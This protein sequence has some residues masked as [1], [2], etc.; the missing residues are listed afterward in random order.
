ML[1][2]HS[3][4]KVA[5]LSVRVAS[6][7]GGYRKFGGGGGARNMIYKL[8][9]LSAIFLMTTVYKPGVGCKVRYCHMNKVSAHFDCFD[10]LLIGD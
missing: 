4:F 5:S 7:S 1:L 2:A 10:V 6:H 8:P 3:K 9:H